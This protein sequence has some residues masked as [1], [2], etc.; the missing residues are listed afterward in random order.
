MRTTTAESL[1]SVTAAL[2]AAALPAQLPPT[3]TRLDPTTRLYEAFIDRDG[4]T[5]HVVG[6]DSSSGVINVRYARSLDGGRT[7]PIR[8]QVLATNTAARNLVAAGDR[9]FV[10]CEA[11][12]YRTLRASFDR[13]GTWQ[14]AVVLPSGN[15]RPTIQVN[16]VAV[17]VLFV[18]S[19]YSLP[20]NNQGVFL[21]RSA[22]GGLTWSPPVALAVGL[23]TGSSV[24]DDTPRVAVDGAAIHLFWNHRTPLFHLA[25]QRSLD[26]GATWLPA[27]QWI[28]NAPLVGVGPGAGRLLVQAGSTLW[29]STN[30]GATWSPLAGHGLAYPSALAMD[31][32]E[33][34][35]VEAVPLGTQTLLRMATSGDAGLTWSV[36]ATTFSVPFPQYSPFVEANVVGDAMFVRHY[37]PGSSGGTVIEQSDD[38]GT[39]WRSLAG[40]ADAAFLPG[41]DGGVVLTW[42]PNAD[43]LWAWVLEG[44]TR[45]GTGNAGTGAV[46]PTLTGR[47]LAGI[48]RTFQLELANARGG[49]LV[50]YVFGLADPVDWP[51]GNHARLHVAQPIG[52]NVF[53]ATGVP[54]QAGV[55]AAT[56]AIAVPNSTSFVGMRLVSQCFVVD[57][58]APDGFC[59]T[60]ARESWIR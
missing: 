33:V 57:P 56:H 5:V 58:G 19:S 12:G 1:L 23:P 32:T 31:G 15:W 17:N 41:R 18:G 4:D 30:H 8:E 16:G 50:G 14:T 29:T 26:G 22:D 10:A 51:L 38:R 7:W 39:T 52:P 11:T 46:V 24:S 55:G 27:A 42:G 48:G 35:A 13:G 2:L 3:A 59:A 53:V 54:G 34:L 60:G 28:A 36:S 20:S 43:S 47:G 6:T 44:H 21:V 9:V 45:Y 37:L 49:A 25:H 40:A